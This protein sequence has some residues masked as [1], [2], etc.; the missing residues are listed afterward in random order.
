MIGIEFLP[1]PRVF[2]LP[3]RSHLFQYVQAKLEAQFSGKQVRCS[4]R[5]S[6]IRLLFVLWQCRCACL[7]Y[8]LVFFSS[9][10]C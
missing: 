8:I 5:I 9:C 6:L 10:T 7:G 2:L 4:I 1:L 3:L